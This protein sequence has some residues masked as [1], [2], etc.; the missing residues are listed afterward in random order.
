MKRISVL[1]ACLLLLPSLSY[2][3]NVEV[4]LK[5]KLDGNLSGYCLDIMGGGNNV[6]PTRGLQGHTCYSYRGDLGS[7]QAMDPDLVKEGVFKV[8][9]FDVCATMADTS[10]G[11]NVSLTE[12]DDSDQQQF[13]FA[14]NGTISPSTAEGMC[15]TLA[16]E[17]TIGRNGTSPHQA[18]QLTLQ[19]CDP[20]LA[21]YQQWRTREQHD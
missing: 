2:A 11:T 5:D 16:E 3:E 4:L 19:N 15:L 14:E 12:C 21:A 6:D 10:A 9:G 1:I 8:V 18:K 13:V 20:E 7:D 17:T